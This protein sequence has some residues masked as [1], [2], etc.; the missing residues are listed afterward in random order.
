[1]VNQEIE[2]AKAQAQQKG[3]GFFGKWKA[4]AHAGF[5]F[6]NRYHNMPPQAILQEN[7]NN[8]EVRPEQVKSVKIRAGYYDQ[9]YGQKTP[10]KMVIK[11]TGGKEKFTF[12]RMDPRQIKNLLAP[13]L[14]I[15]V[16]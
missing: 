13:L 1:M 3:E 12:E 9:E 2:Q 6:H 14:G 11:W 8:Y 10:G 5:N 4:S 7:P 15:K 16:K